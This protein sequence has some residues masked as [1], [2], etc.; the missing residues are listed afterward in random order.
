MADGGCPQCEWVEDNFG[1]HLFKMCELHQKISEREE[2][3][4]FDK[5]CYD[6]MSDMFNKVCSILDVGEEE[7]AAAVARDRM[8]DIRYLDKICKRIDAL[9][10]WTAINYREDDDRLDYLENCPE[11]PIKVTT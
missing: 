9:N 11:A 10:L 6:I 8:E 2:E 4:I 3:R 1:V 5:Q 7:D